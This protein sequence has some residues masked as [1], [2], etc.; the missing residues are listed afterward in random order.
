LAGLGKENGTT[1]SSICSA[2]GCMRASALTR[3]CACAALEALALK[4]AMNASMW[5]R[6]S[7]CFFLSLR[8]EALLLAPR[9]LEAVVA[10]GVEGELALGQM[11]DG[12]DGAVQQ[13]AIDG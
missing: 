10:A 5:R 7:S 6:S 12:G 1:R 3:L 11:Q 9:L 2:I 4:R 13:L 8:V